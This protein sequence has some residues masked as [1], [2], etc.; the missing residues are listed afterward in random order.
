MPLSV[1][2]DAVEYDVEDIVRLIFE[3]PAAAGQKPAQA[4]KGK[5]TAAKPAVDMTAVQTQ[6]MLDRA[7]FSPGEIDGAAGTSTKRALEA[8]TKNGGRA[9]EVPAD[10]VIP[11]KIT[12]Q[13][14][15]GPFTPD[16]PEDMVEKGKLPALGYT[17]LL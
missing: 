7:G 13:D 16:I 11:Y 9:D 15:A 12:E 3:R 10:A 17:S 14:A 5:A 2:E 4:G 6:V 1:G 8:F